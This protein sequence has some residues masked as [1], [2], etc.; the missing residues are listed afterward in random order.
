[1]MDAISIASIFIP[2][3]N[4][5]LK[6][7]RPNLYKMFLHIQQYQ[8]TNFYDISCFLMTEIPDCHSGLGLVVLGLL[9]NCENKFIN[10]FFIRRCFEGCIM[11]F[12]V[13]Y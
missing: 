12:I 7:A 9:K 2:L 4:K 6:P 13:H 8:G 5:I 3:Y 10:Q 1:M 11:C